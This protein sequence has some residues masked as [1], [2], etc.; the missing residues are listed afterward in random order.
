V[1]PWERRE[2]GGLYY[3]RSRKEGGR[4]VREYVGGGILGEL[5]ARMDAEERRR[6]QEEATAW[7]EERKSLEALDAPVEELYRVTEILSRA[8]FVAAGYRQHNR[9]EWRMRRGSE[10]PENPG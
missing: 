1:S 7:R 10:G 9:G 4:V 2:R 3:T 6:R 8:V 5:A